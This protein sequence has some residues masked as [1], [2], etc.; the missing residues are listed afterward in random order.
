MELVACHVT[1]TS[2]ATRCLCI[3]GSQP[4]GSDSEGPCIRL[5]VCSEEIDRGI[6]GP[7]TRW[8]LF[9]PQT[10]CFVAKAFYAAQ[11]SWY[12]QIYAGR[13]ITI[14]E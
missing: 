9:R 12:G 8:T 3:P 11:E 2:T 5:N 14:H 10:L 4:G 1:F 6:V 7:S 13:E